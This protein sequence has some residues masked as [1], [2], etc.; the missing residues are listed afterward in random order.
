[1]FPR[2]SHALKICPRPAWN[3]TVAITQVVAALAV[4]I[5]P[6]ATASCRRL[7]DLGDSRAGRPIDLILL[8]PSIAA[9]LPAMLPR[10]PVRPGLAQVPV[11]PP[12]PATGRPLG[13]RGRSALP[14]AS[15][16]LWR[17]HRVF[18]PY[19]TIQNWVEAAGE[20]KA[21]ELVDRPTSTRRWPTS[22]AT[23]PSTR[24]TT[25]PS[26]SSRSWTTAGT[27]AWPSGSWTT[28]RL[29]TTSVAFLS[30]FKGNWTAAA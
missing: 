30:E 14:S 26:A 29:K 20:K 18:V 11:H 12:R 4:A 10:R 25:A 3:D 23:W 7:H 16:H 28:T 1:M 6:A 19:A 9:R 8:R 15:W 24:S 13:G 27:T 5:L 22:P 2:G 21:D 17:D